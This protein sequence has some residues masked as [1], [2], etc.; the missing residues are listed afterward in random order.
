M[1]RTSLLFIL[2]LFFGTSS[3]AQKMI[4]I[5]GEVSILSLRLNVRMW[6]SR[7]TGFE[8]F[9]GISTEI[10]D[11]KPNDL[12]AGFKILHTF[13]YDQTERLYIGFMG[14]WKWVN[15]F[16]SYKSTGLPIPA[17]IVG[18]EIYNRRIHLRGLAV[19]LGYQYGQK[20]YE[21]YTPAK[22]YPIGKEQFQE[23]PLIFNLRYT[24]YKKNKF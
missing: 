14:R 23:F 21:I 3:F 19:E 5:G 13:Q 24:F 2:L 12:E 11:L 9:G 18:K 15:A 16:T 7:Y 6:I 4:G 22:H 1:K 8:V 20:E 17:L 10:D